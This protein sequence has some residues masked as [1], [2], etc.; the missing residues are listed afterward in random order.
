MV[1]EMGL[2]QLT[3]RGRTIA[4]CWAGTG[5]VVL[6]ALGAGLA[7]GCGGG[8]GYDEECV[9]PSVALW[10]TPATVAAGARTEVRAFVYWPGWFECPADPPGLQ[11]QFT[12]SDA[13]VLGPGSQA[14][15][16]DSTGYAVAW[17]AGVGAGTATVTAACR[18]VSSDPVTVTVTGTGNAAARPGGGSP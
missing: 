3:E 9:Q 6:V 16:T 8:A 13:S 2:R 7:Q 12:V 17:F 15:T 1:R 18:G 4:R 10:V 5:L 14:A 11:V